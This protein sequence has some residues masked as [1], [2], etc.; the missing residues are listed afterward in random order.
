MEKTGNRRTLLFRCKVF[1][2][3]FLRDDK[4]LELGKNKNIQ[5]RQVYSMNSDLKPV[6]LL[7]FYGM[8]L[9]FYKSIIIFGRP[10]HNLRAS[11]NEFY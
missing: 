2:T 6:F 9:P 11:S 10:Y 8:R 7:F 4:G 5:Q 3:L 1:C